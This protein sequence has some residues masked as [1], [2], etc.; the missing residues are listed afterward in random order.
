MAANKFAKSDV[1]LDS[2]TGAPSGWDRF[3]SGA[4]TVGGNFL[5]GLAGGLANYNPRNPYSSFGAA[6]GASTAGLQEALQE[7]IAARK[8]QFGREQERLD[9]L[10]KQQTSEE[11]ASGQASRASILPGGEGFGSANM[12]NIA[13]AIAPKPAKQQEIYDFNVG[14]YPSVIQQDTTSA[15]RVRNI[16]MGGRQ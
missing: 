8:L 16:L 7:P 15:G 6:L 2:P 12:Q 14:V 11:I 4:G 1:I 3:L 9:A 10:S 13:G 5:V